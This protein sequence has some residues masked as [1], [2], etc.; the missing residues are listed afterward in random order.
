M[1]TE[2]ALVGEIENLRRFALRLTR[3]TSDADDLVQGTLVRAL[4]KKD[5]FE[6][7]TNLF[8]WASKIMFNL[9]AS[10]YRRK[11]RFE[12]Q[13]DPMPYLEQA[14][15][16][17]SQE[18]T[19]DLAKVRES[20]KRLSKEH[21]DMLVLVC[22]RGMRYEEVSEMLQIPVGTVRSRLS[23]ARKQLQ[24]LLETPGQ[25]TALPASLI[26]TLVPPKQKAVA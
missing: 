14:S 4:E 17:P 5:Y 20:M 1:F 18:I 10:Q 26:G 13:Y 2:Q 7:N 12:T 3:N 22:I 21:R 19:T 24:D 8:S 23:R 11:K 25:T 6:E 9:F 16:G 15:I